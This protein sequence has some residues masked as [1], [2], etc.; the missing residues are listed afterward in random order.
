MKK[1]LI[2]L[3]L[4]LSAFTVANAE[5]GTLKTGSGKLFNE[6]NF[7]VVQKELH[8]GDAIPS[9]NHKGYTVLFR[10]IKGE[11]PVVLN[12]TEKHLVKV[13][14]VLRFGGDDYI[15]TEAL[16]EEAAISVVLVKDGSAESDAHEHK[17]DE[18]KH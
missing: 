10:V 3:G 11:V 5:I 18:H 6:S 14:D 8:K 13:G 12:Q 17:K 1:S 15:E 7:K 9:H 2:A 4:G 16:S